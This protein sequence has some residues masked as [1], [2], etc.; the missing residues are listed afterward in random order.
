MDG[1]VQQMHHVF[2][3][4][5]T[6]RL[7]AGDTHCDEGDNRMTEGAMGND[8]SRR[9]DSCLFTLFW[10][11]DLMH[12]IVDDELKVFVQQCANQC[13]AGYTLPICQEEKED[14]RRSWPPSRNK[15]LTASLTGALSSMLL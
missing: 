8:G 1:R 7:L 12:L 3:V 15:R 4:L 13:A 14:G 10:R 6:C 11:F 2:D 9:K 5:Q